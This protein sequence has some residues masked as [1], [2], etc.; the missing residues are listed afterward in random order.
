M[1][2]EGEKERTKR[3]VEV[4]R[5]TILAQSEI[6]SDI[7]LKNLKNNDITT[8]ENSLIFP[9]N[10]GNSIWTINETQVTLYSEQGIKV[11]SKNPE[12]VHE[13]DLDSIDYESMLQ[14]PFAVFD[15]SGVFK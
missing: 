4:R 10:V 1:V 14:N 8:K 11:F 3:T 9:Q 2:D 15:T 12:D 13:L 6:I 7:S 5:K